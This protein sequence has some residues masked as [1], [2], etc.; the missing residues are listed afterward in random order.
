MR[1][2]LKI[3]INNIRYLARYNLKEIDSKIQSFPNLS[4]FADLLP[5]EIKNDFDKIQPPIVKTSFETLQILLETQKSFIRFGDGEY[6][7]MNGGS[8]GFQKYDENLARDLEAIIT[9]EDKNLLIGLGYGY[10]HIPTKQWR[11]PW[12]KY[13]WVMKITLL[14]KNTLFLIKNM[15]QQS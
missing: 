9:S 2:S 1:Y 15:A 13:T 5:N 11:S 8:I 4:N 6:I 7:L 12:F 14:L 10:F 3:F